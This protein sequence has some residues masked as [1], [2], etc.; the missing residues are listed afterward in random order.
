LKNI[1]NISRSFKKE[2]E[3]KEDLMNVIPLVISKKDSVE[4]KISEKIHEQEVY[5]LG[6]KTSLILFHVVA[7]VPDRKIANCKLKLGRNNA[8]IQHEIKFSEKFISFSLSV[9]PGK[10]YYIRVYLQPTDKVN[11]K[12]PAEFKK[13]LVTKR[14]DQ[15]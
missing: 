1:S 9:L 14:D 10:T 11:L 2:V 6:I 13:K 5:F 8:T 15:L 7:L 3:K 4:F 12:P